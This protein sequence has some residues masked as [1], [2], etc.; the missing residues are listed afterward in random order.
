M[1]PV[2]NSAI[3]YCILSPYTDWQYE[4]LK[5]LSQIYS[6][7]ETETN[8]ELLT[9]RMLLKIWNILFE[10]LDI[11]SEASCIRHVNHQQAKLQLM[12]QYIHDHFGGQITLEDIAA[13]ASISKSSALNIFQ[14]CIRTSPVS[15]L[16]SYRLKCAGRQLYTTEKSVSAI[17]EETG[18]SSTGYFCRKFKEHY[19][20]SPMEYRK[21]KMGR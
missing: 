21:I 12:T 5:T 17:A 2:I 13:A 10:S 1:L 6:L 4:I 11:V 9:F 14:T 19:H 15:Y 8:N 16:I 18:F 20:M 3:P 7:Q